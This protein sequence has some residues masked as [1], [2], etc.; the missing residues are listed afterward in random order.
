VKRTQ[1][2]PSSSY[3][4][5]NILLLIRIVFSLSLIHIVLVATSQDRDA[6]LS[7]TAVK[8]GTDVIES[9]MDQKWQELQHRI[10]QAFGHLLR[11]DIKRIEY[12]PQ[13]AAP[14]LGVSSDYWKHKSISVK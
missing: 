9:E 3:S 13:A 7:I 4:L 6:Q 2:L 5:P 10:E 1:G 12:E 11:E 14:L 8:G